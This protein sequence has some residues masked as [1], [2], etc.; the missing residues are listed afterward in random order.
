MRNHP[1]HRPVFVFCTG[2]SGSTLLLRYINAVHNVTVW[3][4]HAGLITDLTRMQERLDRMKGWRFI[5]SQRDAANDLAEKRLPEVDNPGN[6][7]V[8]WAN[9]FAPTDLQAAQRDFL[10]DLLTVRLPAHRR[11]GFK[12]IRYGKAEFAFLRELFPLGQFVFQYRDP[13]DVLA[14]KLRQFA[15]GDAD[16][17]VPMLR[18]T[19]NYMEFAQATMDGPERE[20][21]TLTSYEALAMD[22]VNEASRLAGFLGEALDLE[23]AHAIASERTAPRSNG[24]RASVQER[25]TQLLMRHEQPL[26]KQLVVRCD[27]VARALCDASA[28]QR[29]TDLAAV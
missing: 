27:T 1:R 23:A 28:P 22:G 25:L 16:K 2:R 20:H 3:G 6:W 19:V 29:V 12:E 15:K 18:A 5:E 14:S 10:V 9:L 4:E 13:V 17:L 24:A 8:E 21:C 7:T 11:W 26:P